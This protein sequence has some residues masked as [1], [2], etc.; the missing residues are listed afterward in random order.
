[1][2]VGDLTH[3]IADELDG[4]R[5]VL[6]RGGARVGQPPYLLGHHGEAAPVLARPGRLDGGVE[7]EQVGLGR[8]LLDQ[9][10]EVGDR[11][12][13]PG[14]LL[15]LPAEV[16]T[17]S[18]RRAGSGPRRRRP[19]GAARPAPGS[20]RRARRTR[21]ADL[22]RWPPRSGEGCAAGRPPSPCPG[23]AAPRWPRSSPWRSRSRRCWRPAPRSW[24]RSRVALLPIWLAS[25]TTDT[26][27]ERSRATHVIHRAGELLELGRH[28]AELQRPEIAGA[29]PLGGADQ[30]GERAVHHP[31]GPE[32]DAEADDE[33]DHEQ[34]PQHL[35][36]LVGLAPQV[37]GARHGAGGMRQR[38]RSARRAAACP[39]ASAPARPSAA[40][41]RAVP[42][43]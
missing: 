38:E 33:G 30:L 2:V 37:G 21:V 20:G 9:V 27:T 19:P 26:T 25:P 11:L 3:L 4:L 10:D 24:R 35:P 13:E 15:D 42:G 29:E 28:L 39:R 5:H 14:E 22:W 16:R 34:Q 36:P 18:S 7:R 8:D 1:M 41:H 31:H 40:P 6:R 32:H 12:G 43:R 23:P 17:T